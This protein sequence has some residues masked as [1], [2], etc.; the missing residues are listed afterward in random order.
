MPG[1]SGR[2]GGSAGGGGTGTCVSTVRPRRCNSLI[3]GPNATAC[4]SLRSAS[5]RRRELLPPASLRI[6]Q[7][8]QRAEDVLRH[9]TDRLVDLARLRKCARRPHRRSERSHRQRLGRGRPLAPQPR[10]AQGKRRAD[11]F[12]ADSRPTWRPRKRQPVRQRL[13]QTHQALC[14]PRSPPRRGRCPRAVAHARHLT[15]PATVCQTAP[16]SGGPPRAIAPVAASLPVPSVRR[17]PPNSRPTVAGPPRSRNDRF[18][19][20]A[21]VR[22]TRFCTSTGSPSRA[23]LRS[24]YAAGG[25]SSRPDRSRATG[26][27]GASRSS[28]RR[29]VSPMMPSLSG[30][31]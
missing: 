27:N 4:S 19:C 5:P 23:V 15:S 26:E 16:A 17:H 10:P 18:V 9:V 12:T 8:P 7:L 3:L 21:N 14:A 11:R 13:R 29:C 6:P 20:A 2:A 28:R 1:G 30:G 24:T 25:P 31:H 22:M